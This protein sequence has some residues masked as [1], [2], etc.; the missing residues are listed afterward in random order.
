MKYFICP[1]HCYYKNESEKEGIRS[2]SVEPIHQLRF[3]FLADAETAALKGGMIDFVIKGYNPGENQDAGKEFVVS[4]S[5]SKWRIEAEEYRKS[6]MAKIQQR[7]K[8]WEA[9]EKITT[10][11]S[12]KEIKILAIKNTK[13]RGGYEDNTPHSAD[14]AYREEIILTNGKLP[15][16]GFSPYYRYAYL[17]SDKNILFKKKFASEMSRAI[18]PEL[19][20]KYCHNMVLR[21]RFEESD[22]RYAYYVK[23]L[24]TAFK[25]ILRLRA[26]AD[27]IYRMER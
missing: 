10:I 8:M 17:S 27:K 26:E 24:E 5:V 20:K 22:E 14:K 9:L 25:E 23:V 21:N 2:V 15:W 13:S 19:Y 1:A 4:G 3:N 12:D 16:N 18:H 11:Y 6:S 7:Q